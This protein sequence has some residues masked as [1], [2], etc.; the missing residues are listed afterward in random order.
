MLGFTGSQLRGSLAISTTREFLARTRPV[1]FQS[2]LEVRDWGAELVNQL[3]GRVKS[4][5]V[6]YGVDLRLSTPVSIM[7]ADLH[8]MFDD[9]G[10]SR[11]ALWFSS[12]PGHVAVL[13]DVVV[14]PGVEFRRL[15]E[16]GLPVAEGDFVPF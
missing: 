10:S 5:M 16:H 2:D 9:R 14:E 12:P 13:V 4:R 8:V 15:P 1:P 3:V 7:G 6:E 11:D